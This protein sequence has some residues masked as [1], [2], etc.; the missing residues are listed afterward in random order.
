M[1]KEKAKQCKTK[2]CNNPVLFGKYCEHCK[3]KRKEKR[4]KIWAGIVSAAIL[5]VG[6]KMKKGSNKTSS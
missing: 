6:F 2:G 1:A 5:V 4:D 3:Q